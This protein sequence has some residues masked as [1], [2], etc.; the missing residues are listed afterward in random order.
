MTGKTSALLRAQIQA[1]LKQV[2][3]AQ[4]DRVRLLND[5]D[6]QFKIYLLDAPEFN[7]ETLKTLCKTTSERMNEISARIIRVRDEFSPDCFGVQRIYELV[8]RLQENEQAK[9]KL[10]NFL[11]EA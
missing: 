7:L 6:Q 1:S 10:V 3:D 11:N 2:F 9:F 5:F 8:N 4:E